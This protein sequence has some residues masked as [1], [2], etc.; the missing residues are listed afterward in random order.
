MLE[1]GGRLREAARRTGIARADWLDLSTGINPH[2]Y[3]VPSLAAEAWQRLP[4]VD[5]GLE[6]A[7]AAYYGSAELLPVAG[8]QAALQ[9]LP[10]CFPPGRVLTLAPT[11]AEHPHAWRHHAVTALPAAA[12]GDDAVDRTDTL[13]LVQPNNPDGQRFPRTRLLAWHAR[14][15][16]RGGRLIV[17]EAF[18]DA[19]PVDS[20]TPLAGTPGLVVLRSLGK[21]FGLAGARVGFMFAEA[22]L[23]DALAERLGPWTVAGPARAVATAALQDRAWQTATRHRLAADCRRLAGLLA[24]HGLP[25][26]AGTALFQ[27]VPHGDAAQ[28]HEALAR[29]GILLRLFT[30]PTGLRFGL[31][32]TPAHWDRLAAALARL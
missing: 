31:P 15:Q 12:L 7:A 13:L 21:F 8:T 2:G 27:W 17:D 4:E 5:D 18:A 3:P 23:R 6:A 14:L 19:D 10:A 16:A 28:I 9:A 24:A 1:H 20:L 22:G 32:G 25:P 30:A 11:Y 29:Q 26:A